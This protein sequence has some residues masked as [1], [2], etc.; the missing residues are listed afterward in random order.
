MNPELPERKEN[1]I[2]GWQEETSD[3]KESILKFLKEYVSK[4]FD[5]RKKYDN[6]VE[7]HVSG[8]MKGLLEEGIEER[9]TIKCLYQS[10]KM[11]KIVVSFQ[12]A[13]GHFHDV[14]LAG[15]A[16]EDYLLGDLEK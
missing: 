10:E 8:S 11:S 6:F 14:H 1:K 12:D 2:E 9:I 16:L 4:P 5:G 15:K 3:R 13:G 7:L